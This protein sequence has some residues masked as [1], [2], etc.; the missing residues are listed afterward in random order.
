MIKNKNIHARIDEETY[1]A[2]KR[3]AGEHQR[4]ISSL[5]AYIVAQF[6][7]GKK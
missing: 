4:T 7:R 2:L 5:V 6:F 3:G 1:G